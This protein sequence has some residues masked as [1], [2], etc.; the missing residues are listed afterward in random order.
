MRLLLFQSNPS[1]QLKDVME[2]LL[3]SDEARG[4]WATGGGVLRFCVRD[5]QYLHSYPGEVF[6]EKPGGVSRNLLYRLY[7][8]TR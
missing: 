4:P 1:A 6:F 7:V 2:E 3:R 5:A 8:A